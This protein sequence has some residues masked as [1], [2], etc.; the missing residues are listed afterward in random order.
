MVWFSLNDGLWEFEKESGILMTLMKI[1][2]I[3]W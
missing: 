3:H 1:S 2:L